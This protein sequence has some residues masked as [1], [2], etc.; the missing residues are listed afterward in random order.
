[1]L[2]EIATVVAQEAAT[3]ALEP[4]VRNLLMAQDVQVLVDGPWRRAQIHLEEVGTVNGRPRQEECLLEAQ[5][6]LYEALSL[7]QGTARE[8]VVAADLAL[9]FGLRGARDEASNW[10]RR[11]FDAAERYLLMAAGEAQALLRATPELTTSLRNNALSFMPPSVE[12]LWWKNEVTSEGQIPP[13]RRT[14]GS[15]SYFVPLRLRLRPAIEAG[16]ELPLD[17][18]QI[19]PALGL[20]KMSWLHA[21]TAVWTLRLPAIRRLYD[22]RRAYQQLDEYRQLCAAFGVPARRGRLTVDLS[23]QPAARVAYLRVR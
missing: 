15:Q 22:V 23:T 4:L 14:A 5:R 13:L 18:K 3:M 16:R 2:V 19:G 7:S 6:A 17:E 20:P 21:K 8:A 1:M 11:S 12:W 10:A 9:V